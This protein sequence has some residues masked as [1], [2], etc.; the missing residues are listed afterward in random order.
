MLGEGFDF[1]NLKIAAL[2][3]PHR[4]LAVTLQFIG[5]FAR[6]NA[7]RIGAAKFVAV[8]SDRIEIEAKKLYKAGAVWQDLSSGSSRRRPTASQ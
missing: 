5:R 1:P 6:T 8:R 2:H 7:E 4:S 3:A